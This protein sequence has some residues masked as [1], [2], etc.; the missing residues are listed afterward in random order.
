MNFYHGDTWEAHSAGT[1]ETLVRPLAVRALAD[2]GIDISHHRSKTIEEFRGTE[3]DVVV[4]VCDSAKEACP[5]FPG[6][7]V[8]HK[9]FRD[10]SRV[11]AGEEEQQAA[12]HGV[13]DEI[14][15]WLKQL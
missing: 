12:W 2:L 3:F 6:K 8:I 14:I 7:Q 1:E 15:A 11:Q 5:F 4:T 13:R 10:P 9:A